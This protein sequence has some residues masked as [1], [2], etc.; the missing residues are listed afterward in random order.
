MRMPIHLCVLNNSGLETLG[1]L[2]IDRLNVAV[3]LLLRTLLV[4]TLSRDSDSESE[5]NALDTSLPDLLVQLGVKTDIGRSLDSSR[6]HVSS[7]PSP[8]LPCPIFC[9]GSSSVLFLVP[10]TWWRTP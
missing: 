5:R 1:I 7:N 6:S 8:T 2:H 3:Q 4:V 9:T 10:L